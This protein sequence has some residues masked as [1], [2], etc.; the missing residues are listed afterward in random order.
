MIITVQKISIANMSLW[1]FS[2]FKIGSMKDEPIILAN[3]N[4]KAAFNKT[5]SARK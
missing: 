4:A 3:K 1:R 2:I 5:W